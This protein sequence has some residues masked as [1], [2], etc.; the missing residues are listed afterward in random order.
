MHCEHV[1]R[2]YTLYSSSSKIINIELQ[3][4]MFMI[5]TQRFAKQNDIITTADLQKEA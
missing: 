3:I 1:F 2:I 4:Y 5:S